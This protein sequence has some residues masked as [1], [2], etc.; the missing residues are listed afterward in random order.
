MKKFIGALVLIF[1][2]S[3]FANSY[4]QLNLNLSEKTT[5]ATAY[6]SIWVTSSGNTNYHKEALQ[7]VND[8]QDLFQSG[9]MSLFLGQKIKD[10]Q[11]RYSISDSEAL[12]V[13][14]LAAER[15]L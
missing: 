6:S 11:S 9:H 14:L 2:I 13:L 4:A 10:V 5:F 7:V 3:A 15:I 8:S 1:S 12:D